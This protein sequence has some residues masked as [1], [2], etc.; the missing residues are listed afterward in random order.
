MIPEN[1]EYLKEG[2][3]LIERAFEFE[4]YILRRTFGLYFFGWALGF[5]IDTIPGIV[6]PLF[7]HYIWALILLYF[8]GSLS[9]MFF[10]GYLFRKAAKASVVFKSPYSKR[11]GVIYVLFFAF[12]LIIILLVALLGFY[13]YV[14]LLYSFLGLF[15]P[16]S[17]MNVI[18]KSISKVYPEMWVAMISFVVA[19]IISIAGT[20]TKLYYILTITWVLE[21]IVWFSCG[22]AGIHNAYYQNEMM[23]DDD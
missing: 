14:I 19:C 23:I 12:I 15:V 10:T 2:R 13:N 5:L 4:D 1:Q 18:R 6:Y 20:E 8:S 16:W 9:I 7:S 21:A 11:N 22:I 17:M 3:S